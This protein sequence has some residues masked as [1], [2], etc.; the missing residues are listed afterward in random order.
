M[1]DDD[2]QNVWLYREGVPSSVFTLII[3]GR[4]EVFAG[5]E[6]IALEMGSWSVLATDALS[7]DLFVPTFSCRVVQDTT[8]MQITREAY[9][10]MLRICNNPPSENS[11]VVSTSSNPDSK[12]ILKEVK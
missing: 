2:K 9:V 12:S 3:S 6:S 8:L 1:E 11:M 4:V 7:S 10:E 5:K